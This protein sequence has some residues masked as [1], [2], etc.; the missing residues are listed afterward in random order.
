MCLP[1]VDRLLVHL[2]A[3]VGHAISSCGQ[4]RSNKDDTGGA[5]P[6]GLR[7]DLERAVGGAGA[8]TSAA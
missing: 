5:Y 4:I 3:N 8:A 1:A 7:I 6:A 2:L